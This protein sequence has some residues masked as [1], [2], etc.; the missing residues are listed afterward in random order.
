MSSHYA[1]RRSILAALLL[2]PLSACTNRDEDT[3]SANTST[4]HRS[5]SGPTYDTVTDIGESST[6]IIR[7][8]F[9][10]FQEADDDG[11]NTSSD[12]TKIH[13]RIGDFTVTDGSSDI[14]ARIQI[15][16][17]S[18]VEFGEQDSLVEGLQQIRTGVDYLIFA[19]KVTKSERGGLQQY[20]DLYNIVGTSNGVFTVDGDTATSVGPGVPLSTTSA[21]SA[22]SGS[23]SVQRSYSVTDLMSVQTKG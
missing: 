6:I 21:K 12:A 13:M 7:G 5:V 3:S 20:G 22:P 23:S 16:I 14:P 17:D 1:K 8:R 11:G 10:S 19:E 9:V 2:L 18:P 4:T 15:A